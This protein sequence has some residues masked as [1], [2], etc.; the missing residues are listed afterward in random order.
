MCWFKKKPVMWERSEKIALLF[1]IND[2]RGGDNDLNGCLNDLDL[3][4]TK[5]VGFQ[6]REFRDAFVT[7]ACFINQLAM[8]IDNAIAGDTIYVHYSGHGTFV[9]DKSGDEIDGYDEALYLY[10][11]VLIDDDTHEVLA[12]IKDGVNVIIALDS[13][14]SGDGTR[15]M[16]KSRF[17]PYKDSLTTYKRLKKAVSTDM[18]HIVFSGCGEQQT[19]AD[20][21]INGQY[22]G[23]F[24]YFFANTFRENYTYK[25]WY[26]QLR[27]YLPSKQ[28][29]QIPTLEGNEALMNKV[30]FK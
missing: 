11:G 26:D 7:R 27:A 22:N 6:I 24:T 14:Y 13:C 29:D 2:Y 4:K 25:Q 8:A 18:K 10:D 9:P 15:D 3:I 21:Y 23:A 30:V 19:S 28:F 20:A 16:V 1:G 17:K 12:R 5:L